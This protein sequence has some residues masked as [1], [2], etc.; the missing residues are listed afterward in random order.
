MSA[1]YTTSVHPQDEAWIV[2]REVNGHSREASMRLLEEYRSAIQQAMTDGTKVPAGWR[3]D[4]G[5]VTPEQW[6]W[7]RENG[8]SAQ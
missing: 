7:L 6:R 1:S 4:V 3:D 5:Q 2:W 8:W